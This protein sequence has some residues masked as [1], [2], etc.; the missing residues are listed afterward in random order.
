MQKYTTQWS[1]VTSGIQRKN[2]QLW[3]RNCCLWSLIVVGRGQGIIIYLF[4][5]NQYTLTGRAYNDPVISCCSCLGWF[6][7]QPFGDE[8][9]S[10]F[11]DRK[12][13]MRSHTTQTGFGSSLSEGHKIKRN[14]ALTYMMTGNSQT[15]FP[16]NYKKWYFS[17]N[18]FRQITHY[19]EQ[20][21]N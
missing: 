5:E 21:Q 7:W 6:P 19:Y 15:I 4:K 8:S 13:W 17:I 20:E 2:I 3:R 12:Q 9:T 1:L 14:K 18:Y 10:K 11:D 16:A